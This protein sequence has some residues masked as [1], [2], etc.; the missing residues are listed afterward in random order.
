MIATTLAIK[1]VRALQLENL[2]VGY[3]ASAVPDQIPGC[4]GLTRQDLLNCYADFAM[5]GWVPCRQQLQQLHSELRTELD[6][7]FAGTS[8][9]KS[10]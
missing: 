6:D 3:L 9:C 8:N 4:D 10:W 7:F 1:S 5:Y 2:L